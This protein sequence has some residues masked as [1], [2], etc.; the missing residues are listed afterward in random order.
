M[1]VA[2]A[3][4]LSYE[5]ADRVNQGWSPVMAL[6][7]EVAE[8]IQ[9]RLGQDWTARRWVLRQMSL[10]AGR[11][12]SAGH[13]R[14]EAHGELGPHDPVDYDVQAFVC[15]QSYA[16]HV[17]SLRQSQE[18]D[19]LRYFR[20]A[21][22]IDHWTRLYDQGGH[23]LELRS[24]GQPVAGRGLVA[25]VTYTPPLLWLDRFRAGRPR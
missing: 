9:S 7:P 18:L 24:G 14:L 1:S 11:F 15:G 12:W 16:D 6:L 19:V 17:L 4:G 20:T 13:L 3:V 5:E 8:R 2:V 25:G 23:W 22:A 21:L 10:T